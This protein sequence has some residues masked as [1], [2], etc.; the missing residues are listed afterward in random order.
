[1]NKEERLGILIGD[2]LVLGIL[3]LI[4]TLASFPIKFILSLF[5]T[6]ALAFFVKD[7]IVI[8][9]FTLKKPKLNRK[10]S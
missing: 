4:F 2:L 5:I 9:F 6:V 8:A 1:M 10:I 7:L 3:F